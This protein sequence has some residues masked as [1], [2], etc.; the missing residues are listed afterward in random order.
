MISDNNYEKRLLKLEMIQHEI[1][2]LI[3]EKDRKTV[4][5]K[6]EIKKKKNISQMRRKHQELLKIS[7][8]IN[9]R[10]MKRQFGV[11]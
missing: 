4:K 7:K 11:N 2:Y 5:E 1:N 10:L 9:Q 3:K 8:T 6:T